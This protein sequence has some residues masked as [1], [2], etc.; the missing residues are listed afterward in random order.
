MINK[1]VLNKDITR[2]LIENLQ[3]TNPELLHIIVNDLSITTHV[4]SDIDN[5]KQYCNKSLINTINVLSII[6]NKSI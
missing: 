2:E 4:K 5:I 6:N 1:D 3:Y